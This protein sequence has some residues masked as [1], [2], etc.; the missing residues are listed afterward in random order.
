MTAAFLCFAVILTQCA[1]VGRAAAQEQSQQGEE[2]TAK[3]FAGAETPDGAQAVREA[4]R[5]MA[6]RTEKKLAGFSEY[7][8]DMLARFSQERSVARVVFA[9][10]SVVGLLLLFAGWLLLRA[11]FVPV[12][13]IIGLGTGAFLA[14]TLLSGVLS[15]SPSPDASSSGNYLLLGA[16]LLAAVAVGVFYGLLAAKVK[17]IAAFFVVVS[18]F[19][20]ISTFLFPLSVIGGI[21]VAAVGLI[22]AAASM[23]RLRQVAIFSTSL[24]GVIALMVCWGLLSNLVAGGFVETSFLWVTERPLMACLIMVAAILAGVNSQWATGPGELGLKEAEEE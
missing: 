23:A 16:M 17:P 10:G 2:L 1:W 6:V 9:A 4:A 5:E 20:A 13:A 21:I 12:S 7:V 22:F 19:V 15:G 3:P 8:R 18:P 11:L 14:M 24:M